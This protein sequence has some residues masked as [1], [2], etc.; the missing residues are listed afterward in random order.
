[1]E[2]QITYSESAIDQLNRF[3]E[4]K[5]SAGCPVDYEILIDH[6]Q[7]IPRTDDPSQFK[8]FNEFLTKEA[9]HVE[10]RLYKGTSKRYDKHVFNIPKPLSVDAQFEQRVREEVEKHEIA[11]TIQQLTRELKETKAKCKE[12]KEDK[13]ELKSW[14]HQLE[15]ETS[16][17]GILNGLV[18]IMQQQTTG[19]PT[20]MELSGIPIEAL[21][22][23]LEEIRKRLGDERFQFF[24][25][26][27]LMIGEHPQTLVEIRT[28]I[29]TS[30]QQ[31]KQ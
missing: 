14:I 3:L 28:L 29:E 30:I 15:S 23:K 13:R 22:E 21:L 7:I 17:T 11:W 6:V 19:K 1:M 31:S 16:N 18:G 12:L 24:L 4:N 20:G 8:L 25:G 26:T 9:D 10:V 2:K 5:D 27:A